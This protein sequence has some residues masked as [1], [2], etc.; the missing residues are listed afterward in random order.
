MFVGGAVSVKHIFENIGELFK[1]PLF[2]LNR[3]NQGLNKAAE[4]E[5]PIPNK[6]SFFVKWIEKPTSDN[7]IVWGENRGALKVFKHYG[8]SLVNIPVHAANA[9]VSGVASV[10]LGAFFLLKSL[11]YAATKLDI[12]LKSYAHWTIGSTACSLY[13][14][15]ED[16][17]TAVLDVF[18]LLYHTSI[19]I[20]EVLRIGYIAKGVWSFLN[21]APKAIMGN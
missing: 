5:S 20:N 2:I 14:I 4:K 12:P 10:A 7:R 15:I 18:V 16:V 21:Y 9:L 3:L 8:F 17:T 11:V 13:H 6:E 1:S 19:L